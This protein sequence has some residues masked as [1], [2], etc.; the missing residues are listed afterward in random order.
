MDYWAGK[1]I[2][3][4]RTDL[5]FIAESGFNAI[6]LVINWD[7]IEPEPDTYDADY[8]ALVARHARLAWEAGLYVI[9]DLHQDMY[10]V[11]FGLHGAPRWTCDESNYD[12]FSPIEPWFF[13]YYSTEVSACFD[14]FWKSPE[15]QSHHHRAARELAK[16]LTD[17]DGVVG[18]DPHNEPF[19]GTIPFE[20]F[21]RDYLGPFYERFGEVVDEILPGRIV[22]FEPAVTFSVARQTSFAATGSAPARFFFPHYYNMTV[23]TN[24]QWDEDAGADQD[25]VNAAADQAARLKVPWGLGEMGGNTDTPNL[26]DFLMSFYDMLDQA[27]AASFLWLF[28]RGTG[29]FGLVDEATDDWK[30]VA[31]AFLRPAPSAVAGTPLEYGWDPVARTFRLEWEEDQTTGD[32]EIILPKWISQA[33][34]TLTVDDVELA[35]PA[36]D[37]GGR[38]AIPGGKG[39]P[40]NLSI[41]VHSAWPGN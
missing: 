10:G 37:D 16:S 3:Q 13:N 35:R 29:G 17:I 30:P 33:G 5:E 32:T 6:R 9:V 36:A 31:A 4:D 26:D 20:Q 27:H 34:Y 39:G 22:F 21:E 28:T 23:E 41:A 14:G 2:D 25:W 15:L 8:I 40:R 7:R 12:S 18:F 24:L 19:P 1:P 11:G 38:L